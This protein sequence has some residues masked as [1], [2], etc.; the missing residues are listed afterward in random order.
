[1]KKLGLLFCFILLPL[2]CKAEAPG[3]N[4]FQNGNLH[5]EKKEYAQAYA[6]YLKA[7][8]NHYFNSALNHNL[9]L[10]LQILQN[11]TGVTILDR[12]SS[13][14]DQ[15]ADFTEAFEINLI[16]SITLILALLYLIKVILKSKSLS[17]LQ[18]PLSLICLLMVL[19]Y[20]LLQVNAAI[21]RKSPKLICIDNTTVHSGPGAD[22]AVMSRVQAGFIL[23]AS[24]SSVA[25]ED[26][27][28]VKFASDQIGWVKKSSLLPL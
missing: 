19:G 21:S 8:K 12:A 2:L 4:D 26:W 9:A 25:S 16:F 11:Q 5:F 15:V 7:K 18:S 28:S 3:I 1:M 23:R 13:E 6:S 20:G 27:V 14:L 24:S 10:T 17:S 22:F